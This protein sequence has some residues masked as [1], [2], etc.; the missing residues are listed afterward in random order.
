VQIALE[1]GPGVE[2][3]GQLE[4]TVGGAEL[5]LTGRDLPE[6]LDRLACARDQRVALFP[7]RVGLNPGTG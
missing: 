1:P 6:E 2:I 3:V 4:G 7:R 5:D